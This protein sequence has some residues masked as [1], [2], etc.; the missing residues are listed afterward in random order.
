MHT[1]ILE[2]INQ[3]FV[4]IYLNIYIH[5]YQVCDDDDDDDD[6]NGVDGDECY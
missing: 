2:K 5:T 4:F 1:F 3:E 6:S